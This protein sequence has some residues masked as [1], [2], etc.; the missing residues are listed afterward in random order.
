[1][2]WIGTLYYHRT[3]SSS[4]RSEHKST[5]RGVLLVL[6]GACLGRGAVVDFVFCV[7]A[8]PLGL[9]VVHKARVTPKEPTPP[10]YLPCNSNLRT[11]QSFAL[12]MGGGGQNSM[13]TPHFCK[14]EDSLLNSH[15]VHICPPR[16]CLA[17][18]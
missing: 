16:L 14:Y 11:A 4:S 6:L 3:S 7:A 13:P 2:L 1:M 10:L 18:A 8:H 12:S 17:G 9:G 5:R 15:D